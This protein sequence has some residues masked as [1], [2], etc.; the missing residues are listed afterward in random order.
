MVLLPESGLRLL[1]LMGEIVLP[2][3]AEI[4]V[5]APETPKQGLGILVVGCAELAVLARV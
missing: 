5:P 2:A 1:I 4:D 3:R